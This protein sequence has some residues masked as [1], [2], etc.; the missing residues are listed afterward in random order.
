VLKAE[1]V[2]LP[3]IPVSTI[4]CACVRGAVASTCGATTYDA[5]GFQSANCTPGSAGVVTC[6]EAKKCAA[7][8]GPG[9]TGSGVITCGGNLID[10]DVFQDCNGRH[11]AS[12]TPPAVTVS[13]F[14]PPL[15]PDKGSAYVVITSAIGTVVGLCTGNTPDY[16]DDGAF[17]TDDD[18]TSNRGTPS[19]IPFATYSAQGSIANPS[20]FEGDFLGPFSTRGS[21]FTC[22]GDSVSVSGANLAGAFTS[23]DQATVSDIVVRLNFVAE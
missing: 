14:I 10:I 19:S 9:N 6:P 7:V 17:C 18:P 4:V 20:D 15:P 2:N 21:P 1:G 8:H 12:P 23:C 3:A 5:D 13:S 11:G 22:E 16:G